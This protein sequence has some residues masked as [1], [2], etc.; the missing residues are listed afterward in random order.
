MKAFRIFLIPIVGILLGSCLNNAGGGQTTSQ[1]TKDT[2]AISSYLVQNNIVA[3]KLGVGVWFTVDSVAEGIRPTFNDSIKMKYITRSLADNSILDQSTTPRHFVLDSLLPAIQIVLPEFPAGSKGRIFL[4]SDYTGTSNWI[5]QF[6]LTDVKDYQLKI[7]NA[8]IDNYLSAH[9]INAVRDASGLR[10]T[11]DSLK[12]G[13]KVFLTDE[14]QVNYTAK[15]LSDGT[16]VDQGNS[17]SFWVS[18]L[19]LG[20]RIG[21]QRMPEGSVFTFYVPSSLAYGSIGNG[22]SI[23]PNANLIFTVKLSKVTHH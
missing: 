20:W 22:T 11:V 21:L 18:N 8:I 2:T 15:N 7:D 9:S 16:I 6:Q 10:F 1:L 4:P 5:F 19:I 3:T 23:K 12:T 14:V 17:A 13:S